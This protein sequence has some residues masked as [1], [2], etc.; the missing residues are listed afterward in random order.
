[1]LSVNT[2]YGAMTALQSLNLVSNNREEI[3]SRINTGLKVATVSD[4]GAIWAIAKGITSD[5]VGTSVNITQ[6]NQTK[7]VLDVT[8]S[9]LDSISDLMIE[10]KEKALALTD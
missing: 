3:Q 8:L 4:N 10:M 1:M 5:I 6:L 2:N 9:A 7:S